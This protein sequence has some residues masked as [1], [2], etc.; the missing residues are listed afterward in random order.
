MGLFSKPKSK[1]KITFEVTIDDDE[2]A[3]EYEKN[4]KAV[5]K[6]ATHREMKILAELIKHPL[7][8]NYAMNEAEKELF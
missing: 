2:N 4:V 8:R 6:S 7:K 5:L 1:K 3:I